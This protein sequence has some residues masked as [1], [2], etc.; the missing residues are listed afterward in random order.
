MLPALQQYLLPPIRIAKP[1]AWGDETPKVPEGLQIH[2]LA[3]GLP[4]S[5]VALR[6]AQR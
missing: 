4:A 1:V 6:P 3:T 2:A 5:E